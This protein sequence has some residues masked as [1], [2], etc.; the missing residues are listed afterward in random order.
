MNPQN[1]RIIQSNNRDIIIIGLQEF[2]P[3]SIISAVS[4]PNEDR[5]NQWNKIISKHLCVHYP[6]EEY[7][8]FHSH[9]MMGLCTI[10]YGKKDYVKMITNIE[11]VKVKTGFQGMAENKGAVILR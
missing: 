9:I 4:G 1:P 7:V 8:K 11:T 5:L 10:I 6:K 3:L 2:V